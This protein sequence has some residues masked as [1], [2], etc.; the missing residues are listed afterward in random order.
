MVVLQIFGDWGFGENRYTGA[1][2]SGPREFTFVASN[3]AI[4]IGYSF[5]A[6][7]VVPLLPVQALTRAGALAFFLLCGLTHAEM[8][9]H[10]FASQHEKWGL[11]LRE[12]HMLIVHVLQAISVAIFAT[13]FFRDL[14]ALKKRDLLKQLGD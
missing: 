1:W 3:I 10:T 5:V 6:L 12:D 4:C 2:H 8:V 7:F 14:T 9:I 11:I 13:G